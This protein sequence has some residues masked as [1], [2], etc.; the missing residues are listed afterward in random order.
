MVR[1]T[2]IYTRTGDGGDTRL[3]DMSAARKTD[4]R[5]EAYGDV[6][7]AN[8]FVG[9]ALA[10]IYER[11]GPKVL[12]T[13]AVI[14]GMNLIGGLPGSVPCL[15]GGRGRPLTP[16]LIRFG[17]P[18]AHVPAVLRGGLGQAL[19][20]PSAILLTTAGVGTDDRVA[21]RCLTGLANPAG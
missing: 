8:S 7:E 17:G 10:F 5:V 9:A 4:P 19:G 3:S 13:Y 2:R 14:P 20:L 18:A 6:D 15:P 21:A 12:P 11:R 1:L 16:S